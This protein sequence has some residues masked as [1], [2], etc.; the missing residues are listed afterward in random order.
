MNDIT[1]NMENKVKK[2]LIH[3]LGGMT[4]EE[5]VASDRNAYNM[6]VLT[7]LINIKAFADRMNGTAADAWCKRMYGYVTGG[8]ARLER[9]EGVDE[10]EGT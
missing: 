1:T 8:I 2:W 6:G 9:G 3:R 7:T 4:K 10:P 5:S